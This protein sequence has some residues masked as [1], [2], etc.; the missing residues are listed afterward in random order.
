L[1]SKR[2]TPSVNNLKKLFNIREGWRRVDDTLSPRV[3][4]ETLPTGMVQGSGLT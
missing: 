3:L 4:T 2:L 1:V